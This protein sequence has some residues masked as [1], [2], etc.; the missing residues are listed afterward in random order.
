MKME[1]YDLKDNLQEV[2][3]QRIGFRRFEMKDGL[4]LLNGKANRI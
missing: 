4:M 3:L 2:I 1:I